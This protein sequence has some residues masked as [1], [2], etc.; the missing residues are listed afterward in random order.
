MGREALERHVGDA[1]PLRESSGHND[2]ISRQRCNMN[3]YTIAMPLE[4]H[5]GLRASSI[6]STRIRCPHAHTRT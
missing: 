4:C 1:Q 5:C 3:I 6:L 2:S